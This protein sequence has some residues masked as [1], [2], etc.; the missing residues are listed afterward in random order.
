MRAVLRSA[1]RKFAVLHPRAL[2]ERR[3][4]RVQHGPQLVLVGG[5]LFIRVRWDAT[6]LWIL[7]H[8]DPRPDRVP[9]SE[10][11]AVL[12]VQPLVPGAGAGDVVR[13]GC[14]TAQV[15]GGIATLGRPNGADHLPAQDH[16]QVDDCTPR[17]SVVP[18]GNYRGWHGWK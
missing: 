18:V 7:R 4:V 1:T 13:V 8:S 9:G 12:F 6:H 16:W 14:H 3:A 2:A 15:P 11:L 10:P 5:S 17:P